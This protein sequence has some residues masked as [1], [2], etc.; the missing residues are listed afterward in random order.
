LRHT[1]ELNHSA[2]KEWVTAWLLPD[3]LCLSY[4]F[5]NMGNNGQNGCVWMQ[6]AA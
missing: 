1:H 3:A 2:E 5:E 6:C 4:M